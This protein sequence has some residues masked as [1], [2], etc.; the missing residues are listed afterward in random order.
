VDRP[1]T[2]CQNKQ[3][4]DIDYGNKQQQA[5]SPIVTCFGENSPINDNKKNEKY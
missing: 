2:E 5:Q 4:D 1:V 3:H